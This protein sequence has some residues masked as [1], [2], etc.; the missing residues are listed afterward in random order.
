MLISGKS[1]ARSGRVEAKSWRYQAKWINEAVF[2]GGGD[3]PGDWAVFIIL[4]MIFLNY[5]KSNKYQ[6]KWQK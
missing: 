1:E 6:V 4:D 3:W 5:I 2:D